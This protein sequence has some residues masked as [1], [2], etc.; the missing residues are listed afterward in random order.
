MPKSNFNQFIRECE[1]YQ[2]IKNN[3]IKKISIEP[4][5]DSCEDK[6]LSNDNNKPIQTRQQDQMQTQTRIE[7][8]LKKSNTFLYNRSSDVSSNTRNFTS[9]SN[10][11]FLSKSINHKNKVSLFANANDADANDANANVKKNMF[12]NTSAN[13]PQQQPLTQTQIIEI[14]D[15]TFPS[16][17]SSTKMNSKNGTTANSVS[18]HYE[19]KIKNFKNAIVS[20]P[21]SFSPK[22]PTHLNGQNIMNQS[23]RIIP[24]LDVKRN[25]EMT[26]KKVLTKTKHLTDYNNENNYDDDDDYYGDDGNIYNFSRTRPK[27][28]FIF[29]SD[30][31]ESDE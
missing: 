7:N 6:M 9:F 12:K 24:P 22:K 11:I 19:K 5:A 28:M 18:V 25:S 3:S 26:V 29:N 21:P 31:D 20:G 10:N 16:L 17:T 23:T 2:T 14:N 8:D 1:D 30:A 4:C 13:Q 27:S 15:E